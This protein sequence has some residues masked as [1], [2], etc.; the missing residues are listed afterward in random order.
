M[1][2]A[3]AILSSVSKVWSL[4]RW[5]QNL[6]YDL[7]TIIHQANLDDSVHALLLKMDEVYTFLT[8]AELNDVRSMKIIVER[9]TRQTVECSYFI[10]AYCVDQKFRKLTWP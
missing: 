4:S 9:I 6:I 7:Q 3:W 5:L 2:A 8:T 1:Q 10:Q